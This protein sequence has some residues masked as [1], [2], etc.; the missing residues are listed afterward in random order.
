MSHLQCP[1]AILQTRIS[2]KNQRALFLCLLFHTRVK[3]AFSHS[4]VDGSLS[5]HRDLKN[6]PSTS[7]NCRFFFL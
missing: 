1:I 4:E 7:L 2:L 5:T 6:R 3:E